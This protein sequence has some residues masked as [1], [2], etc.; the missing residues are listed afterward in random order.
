MKAA[1]CAAYFA[2]PAFDLGLAYRKPNQT[3]LAR[4]QLAKAVE[5]KPDYLEA[6][7]ALAELGTLGNPAASPASPA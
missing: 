3:S 5:L 4:E 7:K 6:R 2:A 1:E